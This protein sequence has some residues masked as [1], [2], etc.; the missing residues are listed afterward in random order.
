MEGRIGEELIERRAR[1]RYLEGSIKALDRERE[2]L[3]DRLV[4][5]NRRLAERT[6]EW[7]ELA[8]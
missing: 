6:L 5:V 2:R 7:R 4:F 3:E 1:A 8:K